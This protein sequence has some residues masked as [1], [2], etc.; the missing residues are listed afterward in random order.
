MAHHKRQVRELILDLAIREANASDE[1][2]WD[3]NHCTDLNFD[4]LAFLVVLKL[5]LLQLLS[6]PTDEQRRHMVAV[7]ELP[8]CIG[9]LL[10]EHSLEIVDHLL[11]L[12]SL[13]ERVGEKHAELTVVVW[14]TLTV[15]TEESSELPF[16]LF[17]TTCGR[18][19]RRR[20]CTHHLIR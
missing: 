11:G 7:R 6:V 5:W 15:D 16:I 13:L 2:L 20:C 3:V 18:S 19:L 8:R 12:T 4:L 17:T 10:T 14:V 9:L 1:L